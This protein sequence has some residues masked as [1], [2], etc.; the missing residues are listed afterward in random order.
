M[1][2]TMF[3][4]LTGVSRET[5]EQL[6]CYATLLCQWQTRINLVGPATLGDLWRRHL[7]DSAQLGPLLPV[8]ARVLVDF[9]SGAGFPGLVLA[10]LRGGDVHLI[11]SD[12]RKGVFLREAARVTGASVTIHTAR[13]ETLAPWP[14]DVV[15]ARAVAPLGRLLFLMAPFLSRPDSVALLLKGRTAAEELATVRKQWSMTATQRP[16]R[17]DPSGIIL[18]VREV[19]RVR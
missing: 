1:T 14:T 17:S 10:I 2:P 11:E 16:S 18:C 19:R 13:A 7:W 5:M 12:A 3:Q 9:G 4:A 8:H 15:T 6:Q